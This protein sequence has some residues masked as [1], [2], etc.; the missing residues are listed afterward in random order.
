VDNARR[1]WTVGCAPY[2]AKPAGAAAVERQRGVEL[3]SER[4]RRSAGR[5]A[6]R[7]LAG[8]AEIAAE[9]SVTAAAAVMPPP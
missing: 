2:N 6:G 9:F 5:L 8:G 4:T 1:R 3:A 7:E